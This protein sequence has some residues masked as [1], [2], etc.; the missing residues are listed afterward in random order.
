MM[1]VKEDPELQSLADHVFSDLANIPHHAGEDTALID[2]L[3]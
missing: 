2:S 3:V 1:D